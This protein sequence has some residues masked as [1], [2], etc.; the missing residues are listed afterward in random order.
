[1]PSTRPRLLFAL[2]TLFC[3]RAM[4]DFTT[5]RLPL[6]VRKCSATCGLTGSAYVLSHCRTSWYEIA[7]EFLFA[8]MNCQGPTAFARE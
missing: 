2:S 1:M 7:R 8:S 3:T 4:M 6:R 5:C